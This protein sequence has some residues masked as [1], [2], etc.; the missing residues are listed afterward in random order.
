M[1]REAEEHQRL[2][3]IFNHALDAIFLA[4]DEAR[5]IDVNPA[6]CRITGYSRDAL[7]QRS[8]WDITPPAYIESGEKSWQKLLAFGRQTDE[9]KLLCSDGSIV[10]IEYHAAANIIPGLH[11]FILRDIS[12]RKL[13]QQTQQYL[14]R[15]LQRRSQELVALYEIGQKFITTLDLE[16]IYQTMYD[17]IG[18]RLL[19]S[20]HLVVALVDEDREAI[21]CDFAIIDG[22]RIDATQFPPIP[23]TGINGEVIR[24]G[25]PRI[26]DVRQALSKIDEDNKAHIG[27][28]RQTLSG[29]YVPLITGNK[30]IGTINVQ[31]YEADAY[32]E[33]DLALLSILASQAAAAIENAHLFQQTQEEIRER[34]QRERELAA[35][36]GM[37][38]ALRSDLTRTQMLPVILDRLLDLLGAEGAGLAAYDAV[39]DSIVIDLAHGVHK[40]LFMGL[41]FNLEGTLF[42]HVVAYNEPYITADSGRS[43]LFQQSKLPAGLP[44][45]ACVPL[46]V[47]EKI[48]G[49]LYA[50][51]QAPFLPKE[52]GLL[53]A[54]ADIAANA[55][56]R[57]TLY[58][59]TQTQAEQIAQIIRSVPDGVL[60]LDEQR[61]V[62][63]ANPAAQTLLASLTKAQVGD[64]LTQLGQI[65]LDELLVAAPTEQWHDVR[66]EKRTFE[67]IARPL[68]AGPTAAGWVL[69]MRD[70]TE[71][72]LVQ[73]QLQ[74]Q[75]RL[76][77]VGQL[78]AGIAHDFN[79]LMSIVL[80]YTQLIASSSDLSSRDRER[81]AT[82]GQQAE[83]AA[84]MIQQILDFS[85]RSVMERQPLDL[86]AIIEQQVE[87]LQHTLPEYIDIVYERRP[88]QYLVQADPTR[89]QQII[90]NLALN[91]RDAMPD[92]GRLTFSLERLEVDQSG[93]RL[94]PAIANGQWIRL[95]VRDT[96][97]GIAPENLDHVFEP[98]FT[99]KAPGK[100]TGLGLAQVHGIVAQ[101][102]GHIVVDSQLGTGTAVIVYLPALLLPTPLLQAPLPADL[103]QGNRELVLVGRQRSLQ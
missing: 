9:G 74:Q 1:L 2:Q 71:S 28:E 7:L 8:L 63:L 90:V 10:R 99:T 70:V 43:R 34:Q 25:Q 88:G 80:L 64:T 76:A 97:D 66:N 85:R 35:I 17:E 56:H 46:S 36:A 55:I 15:Q 95:I 91:A 83:H 29:L 81:L 27:D 65:P 47:Q 54:V 59:Q 45:F 30:V 60:L 61:R 39:A 37:S 53:T 41:S 31:H 89:M 14:N 42:G 82:I 22:E 19:N 84:R 44:A 21:I 79:N 26:V 77:A 23:L 24:S 13:A 73:Q 86:R 96:G 87:L 78:A 103:P 38:A 67:I 32:S 58:E 4:D 101:H 69:V 33:T 3:A 16:Q 98:F 94:P 11:L 72:R 93:Q 102:G 6:A 52:I 18:Q 57:A 75:E 92:G 100:G 48:V 62:L 12:D 40:D 5:L 51:R 50:G 68:A 49:A 20:P